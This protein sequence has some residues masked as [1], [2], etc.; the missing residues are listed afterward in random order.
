MLAMVKNLKRESGFYVKRL[1]FISGLLLLGTM[2]SFSQSKKTVTSDADD[3]AGSLRQTITDAVD[4]DT[5]VFS[6]IDSI[7]IGEP[8]LLGDKTLVIDGSTSGADV[9]L[10]PTGSLP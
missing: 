9:A 2:I 8:L 4:G 10:I 7:L 3:G 1:S 6:G 5:I